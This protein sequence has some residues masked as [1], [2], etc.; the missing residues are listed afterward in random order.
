MKTDTDTDTSP[1]HTL[2][3][4]SLNVST[5]EYSLKRQ[6]LISGSWDRTARVWSKV[7][8]DVGGDD[9]S[10][11]EKDG[12]ECEM[13]MEE[14]QEAVWGVLAI[15]QGPNEGCWL[16][17]SGEYNSIVYPNFLLISFHSWIRTDSN[18]L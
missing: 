10:E 3:G 13:I 9:C 6:K 2:I 17:S 8:P 16:T 7:N 4:H 11:K 12:W 15:D 1:K 14:H 18:K 5:L